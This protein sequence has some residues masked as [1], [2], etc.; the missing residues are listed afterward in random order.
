[1]I[2]LIPL[3]EQRAKIITKLIIYLLGNMVHNLLMFLLN[4]AILCRALRKIRKKSY[5]L[6]LHN[7]H[8]YKIFL[9]K[10]L[11]YMHFLKYYIY[12]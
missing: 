12:S 1:M 11:N 7:Y 8:Y 10:F 2:F 3:V 4:N 5:L 6:Y 9:L